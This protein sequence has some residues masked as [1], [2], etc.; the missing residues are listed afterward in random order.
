MKK[1][2]CENCIYREICPSVRERIKCQHFINRDK[3][4]FVV[5]CKNCRF[6]KQK[7][8]GNGE[9]SFVCLAR[10]TDS[11]YRAVHADDFCAWGKGRDD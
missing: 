9:I 4:A 5:R 8:N 6:S 1:V 10:H 2:E 3:F 11:H 7:E